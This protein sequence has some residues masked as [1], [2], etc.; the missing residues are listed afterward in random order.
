MRFKIKDQVRANK[1]SMSK[2]ETG[3]ITYVDPKHRYPYTVDL[4][5]GEKSFLFAEEE[6]ELIK[7]S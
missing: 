7:E 1:K 5:N 4:D 2:G 6:L 3:I